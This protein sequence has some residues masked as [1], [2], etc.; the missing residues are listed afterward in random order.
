MSGSSAPGKS[1]FQAMSRASHIAAI[2]IRELFD[3]G[4][5]MTMAGMHTCEVSAMESKGT[6]AEDMRS[7]EGSA[8]ALPRCWLRSP[9]PRG[10]LSA[11][12]LHAQNAYTFQDFG[13]LHFLVP[14]LSDN[15]AL[16]G[17]SSST[18]GSYCHG[19]HV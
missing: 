8:I 3:L 18:D 15:V 9:E 4:S 6:V 2:R 10:H 12:L 11:A 19:G 13:L 5:I 17:R 1:C 7:S 14:Q 16:R